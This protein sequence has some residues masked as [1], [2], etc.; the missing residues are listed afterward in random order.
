[1][2]V[3]P[4]YYEIGCFQA[5]GPSSPYN[6]YDFGHNINSNFPLHEVNLNNLYWSCHTV[7]QWITQNEIDYHVEQ[8]YLADLALQ[9]EIQRSQQ[10]QQRLAIILSAI[11]DTILDCQRWQNQVRKEKD[12]LSSAPGLPPTST[13]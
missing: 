10:Y 9:E 11:R 7:S 6:A 8:R 13:P 3:R 5:Q 2:P 1:M 12:M 4:R